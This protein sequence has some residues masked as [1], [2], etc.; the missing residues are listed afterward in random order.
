MGRFGCFLQIFAFGWLAALI[1]LPVL[2]FTADNQTI[3]QYLTRLLCQPDEKLQRN[4]FTTSR[5]VG[6]VGYS[7]SPMCVDLE[8]QERDVSVTWG[9][10]G[11]AGFLVPFILGL[12]LFIVGVSR[13]ASRWQTAG[14]NEEALQ[15]TLNAA[16][17]TTTVVR[18]TPTVQSNT[19]T[20]SDPAEIQALLKSFGLPADML[21]TQTDQSGA[22]S[23]SEKLRELQEAR[24]SGLISE[25]EFQRL[26]QEILDN[27]A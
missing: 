22:N 23:L 13:A 17:M 21:N 27:M 7:M 3:D 24:D 18:G 14:G 8:G 9:L 15:R 2:P 5:E 1:V 12:L 26:R 20:T 4:M 11:V 19:Y 25:E 6:E 16:G 10:L